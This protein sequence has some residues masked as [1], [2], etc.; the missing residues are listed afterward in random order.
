MKKILKGISLTSVLLAGSLANSQVSATIVD[1]TD[2]AWSDAAGYQNFSLNLGDLQV[3]ISSQPS[4][5]TTLFWDAADGFGVNGLNDSDSYSD[6]IDY[7]DGDSIFEEIMISFS[8]AVTLNNFTV[9]DFFNGTG[10]YGAA[11][12][13]QVSFNDG[14]FYSFESVVSQ[15]GDPKQSISLSATDVEKIVFRAGDSASDF[16]VNGLDIS[17]SSVSVPEP[18]VALL[19]GPAMALLLVR[20]KVS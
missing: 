13:G 8:S 19:L 10:L 5:N 9:S 20:R 15:T 7:H 3:T 18:P 11:E 17:S 2:A 12:T 16:A 4:V 6:E 14:S 1:F